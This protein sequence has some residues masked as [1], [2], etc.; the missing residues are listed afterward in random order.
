M[1]VEWTGSAVGKAAAGIVAAAAP[2]VPP[3]SACKHQEKRPAALGGPPYNFQTPW[4]R[5]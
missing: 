4:F 1:V 3:A 5:A 2:V